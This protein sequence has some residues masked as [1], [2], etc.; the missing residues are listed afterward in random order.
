MANR[1]DVLSYINQYIKANNNKEITGVVMNAVLQY[2]LDRILMSDESGGNTLIQYSNDDGANW[3]DI[4]QSDNDLMRYS[5][6]GGTTWYQ[7][8][9][10]TKVRED[11]VSTAG[12][13]YNNLAKVQQILTSHTQYL[14]SIQAA[15][16]ADDDDLQSLQDIITMIQNN[17]EDFATA[18]ASKLNVSDF[19]TFVDQYGQDMYNKANKVHSHPI[20]EIQD[21][22]TA[23]ANKAAATHTH[24]KEA[25]KGWG[26][27]DTDQVDALIAGF[28]DNLPDVSSANYAFRRMLNAGIYQSDESNTTVLFK[29]PRTDAD[30]IFVG[31]IELVFYIYIFDGSGN[32]VPLMLGV[33]ANISAGVWQKAAARIDRTSDSIG[34]VTFYH[35]ASDLYI[36]ITHAD[37]NIVGNRILLKDVICTTVT[38][39]GLIKKEAFTTIAGTSQAYTL[40]LTIAVV[41]PVTSA[42]LI[43]EEI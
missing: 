27:Y 42:D 22:S 18:L 11:I 2:F 4:R 36:G 5:G 31:G 21:L 41:Q 1:D 13:D 37:L 34:D 30:H 39:G 15:I 43:I 19:S 25:V 38:G 28:V 33:S 9:D 35:D 10:A 8:D 17:P 14:V 20:S 12:T 32:L 40:D 26:F 3:T 7:V 29:L 23:L 16:D 6:D 24:T